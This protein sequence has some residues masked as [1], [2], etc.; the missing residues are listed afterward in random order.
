V[1]EEPAFREN[2]AK[3]SYKLAA[4][5]VNNNGHITHKSR[6]FRRDTGRA[7]TIVIPGNSGMLIRHQPNLAE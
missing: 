3:A 6:H 1:V 4:K 5:T 2:D 7:R